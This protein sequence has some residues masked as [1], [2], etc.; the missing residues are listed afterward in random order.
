VYSYSSLIIP[1]DSSNMLSS[2]KLSIQN[3]FVLTCNHFFIFSCKAFRGSLASTEVDAIK[4]TQIPIQI[5]NESP[6]F[7]SLLKRK[8]SGENIS[9]LDKQWFGS[10]QEIYSDVLSMSQLEELKRWSY[11]RFSKPGLIE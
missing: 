6:K 11:R 3:L 5:N 2:D 7:K 8:S 9:I 4:E 1:C 10:T